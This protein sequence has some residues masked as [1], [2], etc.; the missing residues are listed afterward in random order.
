VLCLVTWCVAI[1]DRHN[2]L[3]TTPELS[4]S[5]KVLGKLPEDG[6]VMPKLVEA[7]IPN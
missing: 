5:Q 4:I 2:I 7:T 1:S 3:S 6:T